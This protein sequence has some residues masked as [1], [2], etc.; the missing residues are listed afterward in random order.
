MY[1]LELSDA[2]NKGLELYA[3]EMVTDAD[4]T[5]EQRIQAGLEKIVFSSLESYIRMKAESDNRAKTVDEL[6]AAL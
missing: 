2:L 4:L 1:T 6:A 3:A 5:D